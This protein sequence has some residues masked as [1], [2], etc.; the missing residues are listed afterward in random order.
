MTT[1]IKV[2]Q[3]A[4]LVMA[5]LLF[6]FYIILWYRDMRSYQDTIPI[7]TASV[8]KVNVDGMALELVW[9]MICHPSSYLNE[10]EKT[11]DEDVEYGINIPANLFIST[12]KNKKSDSF[13]TILNVTNTSSFSNYLVQELHLKEIESGESYQIFQHE[14][15]KLKVAFNNDK[16]VVSYANS[17]ESVMDVFESVLNKK[18][19]LKSDD[20]LGRVKSVNEDIA[21]VS[22]IQTISFDV[23][24]GK[25]AIQSLDS[26]TPKM[27]KIFRKGEKNALYLELQK[28]T[29]HQNEEW[30]I[31]GVSLATDSLQMYTEGS[32]QLAVNNSVS[33]IDS[34]ITYE[35]NDDF[36]KVP[37]MSTTQKQ[38]PNIQIQVNDTLGKVFSY[39]KRTGLV[40]DNQLNKD[41]FPLYKLHATNVPG[42]VHF[43]TGSEIHQSQWLTDASYL[44]VNFDKITNYE[45]FSFL[46]KYVEELKDFE[47]SFQLSTK[48]IS[49]LNGNIYF[50]N[51]SYYP[52]KI[53]LK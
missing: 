19:F 40:E 21:F 8:V 28:L 50:K 17:G 5:G 25:I 22:P 16:A 49:H 46:K 7:N 1:F 31:K 34:I 24:P 13:F 39:F 37:V 3:K 12:L 33:Q 48:G 42:G 18:E 6:V 51:D 9:N 14:N 45:D 53:L 47:M 43:F 10:N 23:K 35:Y 30:N 15:T 44:Y 2:L 4:V 41:I 32:V 52:L 36:E 27:P 29:F 11:K 38:V 26:E 20:F